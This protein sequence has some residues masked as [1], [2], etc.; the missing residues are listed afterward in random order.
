MSKTPSVLVDSYSAMVRQ[1]KIVQRALAKVEKAKFALE[2]EQ[3]K[4]E[5]LRIAAGLQ[6]SRGEE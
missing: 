6:P 4:L 3:D 2:E 5:G 1:A